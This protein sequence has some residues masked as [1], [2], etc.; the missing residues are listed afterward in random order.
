MAAKPQEWIQTK[1]GVG[2][3][4]RIDAQRNAFSYKLSQSSRQW[5]N[6]KTK[7]QPS[8]NDHI[9][10]FIIS[11]TEVIGDFDIKCTEVK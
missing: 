7:S 9:L 2:R 3:P 1:H 10:Q 8:T 6:V 4:G 5:H 11:W